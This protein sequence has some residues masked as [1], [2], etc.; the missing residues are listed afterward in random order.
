MPH[1]APAT[2]AAFIHRRSG[3]GCAL[4]ARKHRFRRY[5]RGI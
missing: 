4:C 1:V 5:S 3:A 2:G